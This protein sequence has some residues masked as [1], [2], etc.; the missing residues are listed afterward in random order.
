MKNLFKLHQA[1]ALALLDQ[2]NRTLSFSE[3]A[4]YIEKKN[5]FPEREGNI[6]LEKQ[7]MLIKQHRLWWI[8]SI[9]DCQS[10]QHWILILLL[11]SLLD[12]QFRKTWKQRL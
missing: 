8:I 5:L 12:D 11:F 4:A 6:T 2:E 3:I 1:I 10:I 7:V 9:Y